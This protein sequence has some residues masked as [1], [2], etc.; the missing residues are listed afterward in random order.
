MWPQSV[1][2]RSSVLVQ[3]PTSNIELI[4]TVT[5]FHVEIHMSLFNINYGFRTKSSGKP[6]R[7]SADTRAARDTFECVLGEELQ[8]T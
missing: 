2:I 7:E 1:M 4:S 6:N 8:L 5:E 3:R